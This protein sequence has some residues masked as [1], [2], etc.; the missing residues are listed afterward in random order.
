VL[1]SCVLHLKKISEIS[2]SKLINFVQ[3][4]IPIAFYKYTKKIFQKITNSKNDCSVIWDSSISIR[5][6]SLGQVLECLWH[7]HS[8]RVDEGEEEDVGALLLVLVQARLPLGI[9]VELFLVV[10]SKEKV[11]SHDLKQLFI[12][13][14]SKN[15]LEQVWHKNVIEICDKSDQMK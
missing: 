1:L 15:R 8:L 12:C 4:N 14:L 5:S 3:K 9:G 11:E 10:V 7:V 13:V 6:S 2:F